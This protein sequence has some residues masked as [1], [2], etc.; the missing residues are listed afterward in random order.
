MRTRFGHNPKLNRRWLE[1]VY[2]QYNRP[3]FV[4]PDPLECLTGYPD[5]ADREVVGLVASALAYGRVEQIL[6]SVRDALRRLGPSPRAA[7]TGS[8]PA[9]LDR[10]CRGFRHRFTDAGALASLLRGMRELLRD[11]GTLN[12]A[13][14][15]GIRPDDRDVETAMNRFSRS[16]R[17]RDPSLVPAPADGSACKRFCLY[18]RWMVRCDDVDPGGWTGVRPAQL[19]VP[20]DTHMARI[21]K[22]LG[23]T[24]RSTPNFAM[25]REV[26]RAFAQF[27]P[28][29]PVRY[30]FALTRFGIHPEVK[31]GGCY[32]GVRV[33]SHAHART[34]RTDSTDRSRLKAS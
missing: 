26:T 5:P 25:A 32:S 2:A 18:L 15:A 19:M 17:L 34:E 14:V 3:D 22:E 30:D 7:I 11:H 29:D 23:L 21:A 27:C 28:E 9:D 31:K 12:A 10:I 24:R 13:F 16:L 8:A 6:C 33:R 1:S 4:H 20:L